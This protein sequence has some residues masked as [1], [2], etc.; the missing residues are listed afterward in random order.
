MFFNNFSLGGGIVQTPKVAT[1]LLISDGLSTKDL[2]KSLTEDG[3]KV[4]TVSGDKEAI[5]AINIKKPDLIIMDIAPKKLCEEILDILKNNKKSENV[6]VI[7]IS[8]TTEADNIVKWLELGANDCLNKTF[9]YK[10]LL[11]RIN[12]QLRAY[13]WYTDLIFQNQVLREIAVVDEVTGLFNRRYLMGRITGEVSRAMR[14]G[15]SMSFIIIEIDDIKSIIN[16][17][18]QETENFLLKQIAFLLKEIVR[19]SDVVIRYGESQIAILCPITD[20]AGLE[21]F[22]ERLRKKIE[23]NDFEFNGKKLR[24]TTSIGAYTLGT[25]DFNSLEKKIENIF[26][27]TETAL[28]KAKTLQGNNIE[29]FE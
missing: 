17:Y 5:Q 29:I 22:I 7:M 16:S 20:R 27:F 9:D 26:K 28:E 12:C 11:A 18:G 4:L 15:E 25:S 1:I 21:I 6:P 2:P 3:F 14:Q 23:R 19:L 10:E 8:Q 24:T 13:F